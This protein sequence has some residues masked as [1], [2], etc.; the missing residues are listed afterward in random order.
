[1]RIEPVPWA[2]LGA[3]HAR[4]PRHRRVAGAADGQD[5]HTR[6]QRVG[7]RTVGEIIERVVADH[8]DG[9]RLEGLARIAV[10]EISGATITAT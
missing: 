10:D 7:W 5:A 8:L 2:R 4:L 9:R 6:R 1:V 3:P